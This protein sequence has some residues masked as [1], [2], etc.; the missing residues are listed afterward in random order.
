M[1]RA[2]YCNLLLEY[3]PIILHV[4][5]FLFDTYSISIDDVALTDHEDI[6]NLLLIFFPITLKI[7]N[8]RPMSDFKDSSRTSFDHNRT[9]YCQVSDFDMACG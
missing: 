6:L 2:R 1:V 5:L 4:L 9:R 8:D 3:S 7:Y